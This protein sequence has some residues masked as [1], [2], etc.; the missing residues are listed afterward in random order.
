MLFGSFL[1]KAIK[2]IVTRNLVSA[3]NKVAIGAS[4]FNLC[5]FMYP[6]SLEISENHGRSVAKFKRA[7]EGLAYA[8]QLMVLEPRVLESFLALFILAKKLDLS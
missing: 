8:I 1:P 7:G 4:Q 5:A 6:V 3:C 2:T